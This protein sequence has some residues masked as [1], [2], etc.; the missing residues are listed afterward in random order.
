MLRS[1]VEKSIAGRGAA[2]SVTRHMLPIGSH[3]LDSSE[4]LDLERLGGHL[5]HRDRRPGQRARAVTGS[6]LIAATPGQFQ[7]DRNLNPS[8]RSAEGHRRFPEG[9]LASLS[10]GDRAL[11]VA[12]LGLELLR[13]GFRSERMG[14]QAL[15]EALLGG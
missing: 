11:V 5:D 15:G 6:A 10:P 13:A 2:V 9:V 14:L 12:V 7:V 8:L 4:P 1:K 3:L